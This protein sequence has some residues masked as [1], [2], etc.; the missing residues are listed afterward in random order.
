MLANMLS[1]VTL[2]TVDLFTVQR[3]ETYGNKP[4]VNLYRLRFANS[5]TSS[6][7]VHAGID[8]AP[9]QEHFGLPNPK[10]LLFPN[11]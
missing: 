5:I 3:H 6:A 9:E 2:D 4:G 7:L 10:P 8:V 11:I 1:I